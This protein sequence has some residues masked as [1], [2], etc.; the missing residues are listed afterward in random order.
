MVIIWHFFLTFQKVLNV[1]HS[2]RNKIKT[3]NTTENKRMRI[4]L[5]SHSQHLI[6]QVFFCSFPEISFVF[7]NVLLLL[8]VFVCGVHACVYLCSDV[9]RC[10]CV[11]GVC[12]WHSVSSSTAL[13]NIYWGRASRW[14]WGSVQ[15]VCLASSLPG[16]PCVYFP[17]FKMGSGT[18]NSGHHAL[19]TEA[20]IL[21]FI[22][23]F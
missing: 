3:A 6:S 13:N 7:A 19:C 1:V 2:H 20:T 10:T 21:A 22:T 11:D 14:S 4:K 9:R 12:M 16:T 8:C 5:P 17:A 18:P 15:P 23:L